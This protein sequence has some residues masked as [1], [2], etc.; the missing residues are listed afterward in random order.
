MLNTIANEMKNRYLC[1]QF[2]T[3]YFTLCN[4]IESPLYKL[5]K[6]QK[7]HQNYISNFR[8]YILHEPTFT[9]LTGA[10]SISIFTSL[11]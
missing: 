1:I 9:M 6:C 5:L 2:T 3:E 8:A 11:D 10:S 4:A 7:D